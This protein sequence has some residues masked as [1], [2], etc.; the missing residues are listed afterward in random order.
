M[1]IVAARALLQ[2]AAR[3]SIRPMMSM[4]AVSAMPSWLA[5]P[6]C[7]T[8]RDAAATAVCSGIVAL[9]AQLVLVQLFKRSDDSVLRRSAGYTAHHIIALAFM[10]VATVVGFAGWFS[11]SAAT[12]TATAR[13]LVPNGTAR[14]LSA[15]ILG[16]LVIWDFPCS[17]FIKK[18][19]EPVMLAH[20]VGLL[21]TTY[22]VALLPSFYATFYLG[23]TELSN[24]PLQLWD[25][26]GHAHDV[27]DDASYPASRRRLFAAIRDA[28]YS[29]FS[30]LFLIVRV[31][32]FTAITAGGLFPDVLALLARPTAAAAAARLP[33]VGFL[34]L[35]AAFNALMLYWF[36]GAVWSMLKP[37]TAGE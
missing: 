5:V 9:C 32:A 16:E 22:L 20:H 37:D 28:S 26:F 25:G 35:G 34:G 18:L 36:G 8:M 6:A 24:I 10:V 30:G 4:T 21:A 15:V 7:A 3:L 12:A 29:V 13:M 14:W 33:L 31:F 23:W 27:A 11:P 19:Q 1:R 17:L 2:P